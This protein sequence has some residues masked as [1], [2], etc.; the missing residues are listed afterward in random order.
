[1]QPNLQGAQGI[2][3]PQ[4]LI[5][6]AKEL[7]DE[8]KKISDKI[9]SIGILPQP[10]T[11]ELLTK[12]VDEILI[13]NEVKAKFRDEML[14]K[15]HIIVLVKDFDL[16]DEEKTDI[17]AKLTSKAID[18]VKAKKLPFWVDIFLVKD[19]VF[20]FLLNSKFIVSQVLASAIPIEDEIYLEAFRFMEL[21]KFLVLS[22]LDRYVVSYVFG[23]SAVRGDFT[24]KSDIDAY[25]IIDDTDVQRMTPQELKARLLEMIWNLAAKAKL[26]A[27]TRREPNIQVYLLTEF[28]ENIK[29]T[30]PVIITFLRDGIPIYDK[31]V[32]QPWKYMLRKGQVQP[33]R[34]AVERYIKGAREFIDKI[35]RS[36]KTLVM[37]DS[38][39]GAITAAQALIMAKGYLPPTPRETPKVLEELGLNDLAEEVREFVNRRKEIEHNFGNVK[40]EGKEVDAKL[41]KLKKIIETVEKLKDK[42]EAEGVVKEINELLDKIFSVLND[43]RVLYGWR[44]DPEKVLDK[45]IEEKQISDKYAGLLEKA[46]TANPEQTIS[47]LEELRRMAWNLLKELEAVKTRRLLEMGNLVVDTGD[48]KYRLVV[49]ESGKAFLLSGDEIYKLTPEG[50]VKSN[51]EELGNEVIIKTIPLSVIEQIKQVFGEN[52]KLIL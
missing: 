20:F 44:I 35:E 9:T 26:L 47:E 12:F 46:R 5:E 42:F 39:W 43:I 31:G 37:E 13:D 32:F 50:L 8:L 7:G 49:S 30:N 16:K 45:L 24:E 34:E 11:N 29:E 18:W 14:E 15:Y 28:W 41:E 17:L 4:D 33:S 23:G 27:Q 36:L 40:V 51:L 19:H 21:H 48:K 25:I 22:E 2:T 52:V 10:K 6:K 38:F 1:M 3:I